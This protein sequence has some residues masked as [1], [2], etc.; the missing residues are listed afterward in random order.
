MSVS[1]IDLVI[2]VKHS[3]DTIGDRLFSKGHVSPTVR[4]FIRMESKMPADKARKLLGAVIDLI[5]YRHN[6]FDD[7][8][9][10]LDKEGPCTTGMVKELRDVYKAKSERVLEPSFKENDC[11]SNSSNCMD[12]S[13]DDSFHSTTDQLE[14]ISKQPGWIYLSKLW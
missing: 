3:Y 5:Q 9:E 10:V 13:S 4:D 8:I 6:I 1:H 14:S 2:A 7:F 11:E 12:S